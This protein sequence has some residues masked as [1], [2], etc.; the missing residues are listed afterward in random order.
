M[1]VGLHGLCLCLSLLFSGAVLAETADTYRDRYEFFLQESYAKYSPEDVSADAPDHEDFLYYLVKKGLRD[2]PLY[3]AYGDRYHASAPVAEDVV[4]LVLLRI[5]LREL[6]NGPRG[7]NYKKKYT[8]TRQRLTRALHDAVTRD[9][10]QTL[11]VREAVRIHSR[12]LGCS[13]DGLIALLQGSQNGLQI[14]VEELDHGAC[15]SLWQPLVDTYGP[16]PVLAMVGVQQIDLRPEVELALLE[17]AQREVLGSAEA[18]AETK[19][20]FAYYYLRKLYSIGLNRRLLQE[21][22]RFPATV[23]ESMLAVQRPDWTIHVDGATLDAGIM[24]NA[25]PFALAAA[26]HDQ[27]ENKAAQDLLNN[28]VQL[29]QRPT[30]KHKNAWDYQRQESPFQLG[31]LLAY[32]LNPD[33]RDLFE[34]MVGDGRVGWYWASVRAAPIWKKLAAGVAARGGYD[35]IARDI[36]SD[37]FAQRKS[38]G[39]YQEAEL[40]EKALQQRITYFRQLIARRDRELRAALAEMLPESHESAA[41]QTV[42]QRLRAT[43]PLNYPQHPLPS[44]PTAGASGVKE[45]HQEKSR[46]GQATKT[47]SAVEKYHLPLPAHAIVRS[48]ARNDEVVVIYSAQD[49]DAVGE[50]SS[51]GYWI[52]HSDNA[53][54]DWDGPYYTGLQLYAPYVIL[55]H[56]TLSL[57]GDG[58]LNIAV[59]RREL[60]KRSITFPPVGLRAKNIRKNL[61]ITIRWQQLKQDSDGDGLTDIAEYK[62]LLDPHHTD[63][64]GDG[65]DDGHDALPNVPFGR[66]GARSALMAAILKETLG[67][68]KVAIITGLGGGAGDLSRV[69]QQHDF[70]TIGNQHTLFVQGSRQDFAGLNPAARIMVFSADEYKQMGDRMGLLYPV[71]FS[72][73]FVNRRG[74]KAVVQW[75][76]GWT[77]GKLMLHRKGDRW[78]AKTVDQWVS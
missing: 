65:I 64:D 7:D 9:G 21:Y 59:E 39:D 26:Y 43:P 10:A 12:V 62:L 53:G 49:L 31:D 60:D 2:A 30:K 34:R 50:V 45:S 47:V 19:A 8:A 3:R 55:P 77:G 20:A 63:S 58:G 42:A 56:S 52:L 75:S 37:P 25:M 33:D 78:V 22:Q 17:R 71:S 38:G 13:D 72:P 15:K 54:L 61:F 23:R 68:D 51:G 32:S 40:T 69:L 76:A 28:I 41:A 70:S 27:G 14:G 46:G 35:E 29:N 4:A 11:L 67:F 44:V 48:E 73:L 74:D 5:E 16:R 66:P 36:A 6:K 1:R 24:S 57:F 18:D